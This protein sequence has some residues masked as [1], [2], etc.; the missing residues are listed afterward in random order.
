MNACE[1]S[2]AHSHEAD[3]KWILAALVP[4]IGPTEALWR[5]LESAFGPIDYKGEFVPF[6]FTDY[7]QEESGPGLLR[8]FVSFRGLGSP[9]RLPDLKR[10][11]SR[12]E[13]VWAVNGKRRFN[14]D[15]GYMDPDKVVLASYK[16]APAKLYL[17]DG[18]YADLLLKYGKGRF[19]PMPW[20]F[21]DFQDGR[22][23][24]G[25]MVIRE[26]LKSEMRR[27]PRGGSG[28]GT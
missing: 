10:S 5:G 9:E 2:P 18:V 11:A 27:R 13:E 23:G 21:H 28:T 25:L 16:R 26:K 3:C 24:K 4:S 22:Y 6:D 17:R 14:L 8:G 19:E 12:L 15:I 7:Y 20:A 1:A